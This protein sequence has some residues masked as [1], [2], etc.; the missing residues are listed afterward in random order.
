MAN[1]LR[2]VLLKQVGE[3]QTD[4]LRR[5]AFRRVKHC[6][7]NRLRV[8]PLDRDGTTSPIRTVTNVL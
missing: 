7:V 5:G 3:D 1:A 6:P 2:R 4:R 8:L